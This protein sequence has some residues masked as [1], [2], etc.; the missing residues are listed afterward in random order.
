MDIFYLA[1]NRKSLASSTNDSFS[2]A[3]DQG[4]G[5]T[6]PSIGDAVRIDCRRNE[7]DEIFFVSIWFPSAE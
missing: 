6:D 1:V 2:P 7:L 4:I 5:S 3:K